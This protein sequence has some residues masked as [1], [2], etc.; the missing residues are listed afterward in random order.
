MDNIQISG[1]QTKLGE[2]LKSHVRENILS[3]LMKYFTSVISTNVQFSKDTFNFKCEIKIHVEKT[4]FV[5]S[6]AL[7]NDAYGAFNI[8]NEKIKKRIRRYHRKL[9]DHR[10]ISRKSLKENSVSQYIIQDPDSLKKKENIDHPLIIAETDFIIKRLSIS[11]ALMVMNLSEENAI[12]FKN[13]KN[14]RIN[15]LHK[16]SD[17]NVGW[18]DTHKINKKK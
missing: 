3:S 15:F 17:G 16:R 5:Q 2:S 7:S 1:K 13:S 10:K 18:I 11:E 12:L 8:A 4:I 6:H 14:N 9:T